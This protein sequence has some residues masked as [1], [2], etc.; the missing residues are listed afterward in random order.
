LSRLAF[1]THRRVG[2]HAGRLSGAAGRVDA[3]GETLVLGAGT[4]I[5]LDYLTVRGGDDN[6]VG[7]GIRCHAATLTAREITIEGNAAAGITSSQCLVAVSHSRIVSNRG[8]GLDIFDGSFTMTRSVMTANQGGAI[9]ITGHADYDL[10]NNLIVKNGDA[11][12]GFGGLWIAGVAM[13]GRRVFEFN[14]VAYN[15]SAGGVPPG[16]VCDFVMVP[17]VFSNNI[18]F[19]NATTT[20]ANQVDGAN[21]TWR[22]SDLGPLPVAGP[23]N[24]AVDPQ[25]ADLVH[26]DYHLQ[27]SSPLRDAADPM[28]M[29]AVDLDGDSRP[30]GAAPDMGADEI[31]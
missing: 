31:K 19:G 4:D 18:V 16:V 6:A 15:Q 10:E 23:G 8:V 3:L 9:R 24:L 14:T 11:A 5:V 7:S 17:L 21:C 25:F 29:Q 27:A 13:D 12:I 22:Y 1:F 2:R 20:T 30:Q 26:D 28:A